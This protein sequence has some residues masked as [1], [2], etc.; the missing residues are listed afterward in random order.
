M[1]ALFSAMISPLGMGEALED[2]I[3]EEMDSKLSSVALQA[4]AI[5]LAD[6]TRNFNTFLQHINTVNSL[7]IHNW[8]SQEGYDVQ[9][10]RLEELNYGTKNQRDELRSEVEKVAKALNCQPLSEEARSILMVEV[11]DTTGIDFRACKGSD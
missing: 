3:N 10:N 7:G 2:V 4:N 11:T 6:Q 5:T 8:F 9:Y 1:G